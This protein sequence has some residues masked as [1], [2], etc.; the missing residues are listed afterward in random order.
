[1]YKK[2]FV[3]VLFG[4]SVL[5]AQGMPKDNVVP[6]G[7]V[8]GSTGN[9]FSDGKLRL[10]LH[11]SIFEKDRSYDGNDEVNDPKKKRCGYKAI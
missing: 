9:V 3:S 11:S 2:V 1:M 8:N 5:F 6:L 7:N 10:V 4:A